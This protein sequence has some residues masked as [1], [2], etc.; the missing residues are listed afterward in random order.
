MSGIAEN[1][2]NSS[3]PIIVVEDDESLNHLVQKILQK[4]GFQTQGALSGTEAIDMTSNCNEALMLLDYELKDMTGKEVIESLSKKNNNIPFVI[5]T[6]QGNEMIAVDMMKLGAV[7]YLVKG[8][9]FIE[10][11][12]HVIKRA[13]QELAS[14]STIKKAEEELRESEERFRSTFEHAA[15]GIEHLMPGG[16]FLRVNQRFCDI[17]GYTREE[18]MGLNV[19]DITHPDFRD[20][21]SERIGLLIEGKIRNFTL[22]QIY[23]RKDGSEVW[24]KVTVSLVRDASG[25]P[26]YFIGVLED[27]TKRKKA[28]E[29]LQR[30]E[31]RFRR[32]TGAIT[33]YTYT[34][35]VEGGKALETSHSETCVAVTGYTSREFARD[36]YLWIQM[37]FEEDRDIVRQQAEQVRSGHFPH[38]I[39]HRI[40]RKD[41]IMRWVESTVVPNID[42]NGRIVSYDGM[43]R[44]ITER[45]RLEKG[46]LEIEEREQRR[47]GQDLHDDLGQLLTGIAFKSRG[48]QRKLEKNL[49]VSAGNIEEITLLVN[50]AKDQARLLSRGLLSLETEEESL[51]SALKDLAQNTE[52]IYE[53]SCNFSCSG[54]VPIYNK[55][56]VTHLYRIAQEAVTNAV[57]HGKPALI[58]ISLSRLEDKVELTIKDDGTGK[59]SQPAGTDGMGLQIM[60]YRAN[61]IG[62]SLDI[63]SGT[64]KGTQVKCYFSDKA[65][66]KK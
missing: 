48:L 39:E 62:G 38:S 43:I 23:M 14:K 13:V 53:I 47:I 12:P 37:V 40:V 28:E 41:G 55:A 17:V 52:R 6:G 1:R 42:P 16:R 26:K 60:N 27:I 24:G 19:D 35:C 20:I 3:P 36:P 54:V 2:T 49:P 21:S 65:K 61:M 57:K 22:D 63:Q 44:D 51:V 15:V 8:E 64:N 30:S 31:E 5:V 25:S 11:L 59:P 56:A 46:L 4:E 58:D 33:D 29:A 34:V 66:G 10:I 9:G 7:D 18:L 50:Q 45:K 32:M